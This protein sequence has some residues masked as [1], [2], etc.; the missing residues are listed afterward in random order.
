[1]PAASVTDV[2]RFVSRK[3][4]RSGLTGGAVHPPSAAGEKNT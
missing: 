4:E 2:C 3:P 1:M